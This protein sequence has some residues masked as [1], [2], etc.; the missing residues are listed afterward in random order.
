MVEGLPVATHEGKLEIGDVTIPCVILEDGS[1]VITEQG[2]SQAF[3]VPIRDLLSVSE[4]SE[5]FDHLIFISPEGKTTA[6][7]P[8]ETLSKVCQVFLDARANTGIKQHVAAKCKTVLRG[9]ALIGITA[10]VDQATGYQ[11]EKDREAL[12][13]ILETH[14]DK[15]LVPWAKRFPEDFWKHLFRLRR[16]QYSPLSLKHPKYVGNLVEHLVFEQL[17]SETLE[18]LKWQLPEEEGETEDIGN[19]HIERQLIKVLTLMQ[20]APNWKIFES[21]FAR[22]HGNKSIYK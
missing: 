1:R 13:R 14:L 7:Y 10:L 12:H 20:V 3:G 15:D 16:W 5:T 11:R 22:A 4:T 2:V 8:A 21:L 9:L 18:E 19:R 17:S 6:G